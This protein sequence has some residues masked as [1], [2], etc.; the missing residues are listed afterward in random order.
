MVS[1]FIISIFFKVS[2]GN[3]GFRVY[4]VIYYVIILNVMVYIVFVE[5]WWAGTVVK[6]SWGKERL[7]KSWK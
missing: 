4:L 3:E 1:I 5:L 7:E 6:G 2:C